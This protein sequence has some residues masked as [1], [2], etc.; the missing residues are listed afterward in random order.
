MQIKINGNTYDAFPG[1]K[2]LDVARRNAIEIPTLCH[3]EAL[4]GLASCRLCM[5]E[6]RDN[7]KVQQVASCKYPVA[8][9]MEVNTDTEAIRAHRKTL[10]Q[11]YYLMAPE[12]KRIKGL[13]YYYHVDSLDRLPADKENKC[14]LCGLCVKACAELGT[15]AISTLYRGTQK[16]IG[17]AFDK[18]SADCIG[19]GSCYNVC[20]TG[21]INMVDSEG[22]RTIWGKTFNLVRC[23]D[24]GEYFTTPEAL[25]HIRKKL[26]EKGDIE[27]LQLCEHCKAKRTAEKLKDGLHLAEAFDMIPM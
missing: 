23:K 22:E 18:P 12:S 19:C 9:G 11:L 17:T 15:N 20:P 5:V 21:A 2:I 25:D 7:G 4:P 3:S 24:C 14:V 16:K 1:E 26:G 6:V 27:E 8:D 13:M 10:I